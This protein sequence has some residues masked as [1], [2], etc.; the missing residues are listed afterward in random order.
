M[1]METVRVIFV[2]PWLMTYIL[3]GPEISKYTF[4]VMG[5][6]LHAF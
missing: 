6:V 2:K 1:D 4:S 3:G 5:F